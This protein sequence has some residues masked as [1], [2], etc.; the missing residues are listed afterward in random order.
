VLLA[1]DAEG[2]LLAFVAWDAIYDMHWASA[3]VQIADLYVAPAHRGYGL[4]VDL[5][6]HVAA[7]VRDAGGAFIRGG[8]YDRASTRRLYGRF[9]VVL[10]NGETHLGGRALRHLASLAGQPPRVVLAQ[11]PPLEWIYEP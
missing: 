4:A 6:A 5:I 11:L 8:A 10:P 3:G 7:A 9:A 2:N 1:E